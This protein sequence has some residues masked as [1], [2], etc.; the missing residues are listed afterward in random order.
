[1]KILIFKVITS[2]ICT[3]ARIS[4]CHSRFLKIIY[5]N[6]L[7][8]C[9]FSFGQAAIFLL[10][11]KSKCTEPTA[12]FIRSG[13]IVLMSAKARLCFH[14]VPKI[15]TPTLDQLLP[16]CLAINPQLWRNSRAQ[17]RE[18]SA[19]QSTENSTSQSTENSTDQSREN[20]ASKEISTT[21]A[22]SSDSKTELYENRRLCNHKNQDIHAVVK[23][24]SSGD[25]KQTGSSCIICET[26]GNIVETLQSL[27]W[28]PFAEY[29]SGARINLN[30]RQVFPSDTKEPARER[31]KELRNDLLG[32]P[33]KG[34]ATEPTDDLSGESSKEPPMLQ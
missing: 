26:S 29:L 8:F 24:T 30:I 16:E 20:S 21:T 15:M 18:N 5:C 2:R 22:L 11:G 28:H 17:T 10:G 7:I 1:M 12:M 4:T 14:A 3:H 6:S 19:D 32:E 33:S 27:D 9:C 31:Q 25:V 13:D 23:Q 34:P